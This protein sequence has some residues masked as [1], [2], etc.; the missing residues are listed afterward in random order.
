MTLFLSLCGVIFSEKLSQVTKHLL[1][2]FCAVFCP[3]GMPLCE[4]CGKNRGK[5]VTRYSEGYGTEVKT[6]RHH[7]LQ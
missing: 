1:V 6:Q 3:Q 4:H 7:C 5:M 2:C